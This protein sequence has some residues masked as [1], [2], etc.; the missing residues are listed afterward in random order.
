MLGAT[1]GCGWMRVEVGGGGWRWVE[2][3]GGGWRWVEVGGGGWRW[4]E[5]QWPAMN[6]DANGRGE[7]KAE[8]GWT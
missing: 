7:L 4:V 1:G 2:V 8:D 3:G 5:V 6:E